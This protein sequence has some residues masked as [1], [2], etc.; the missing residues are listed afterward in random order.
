MGPFLEFRKVFLNN[1]SSL[2]MFL[3]SSPNSFQVADLA[4]SPYLA[5]F[6]SKVVN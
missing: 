6:V 2:S 5:S 1:N 3:G 4:P